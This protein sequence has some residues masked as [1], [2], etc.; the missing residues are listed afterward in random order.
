MTSAAVA[1]ATEV[2]VKVQKTS[3][4]STSDDNRSSDEPTTAPSVAMLSEADRGVGDDDDGDCDGGGDHDDD[5]DG[6]NDDDGDDG[7]NGDNDDD[8][9]DDD[10]DDVDD[11]G[12]DDDDDD[13]GGGGD[14]DFQTFSI[15]IFLPHLHRTSAHRPRPP[16]KRPSHRCTSCQSGTVR[17]KYRSESASIRH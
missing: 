16:F 3:E 17:R 1:A 4:E 5:D 15:S 8:G 11:A 9:D 7:D 2:A 12:D 14:D 10:D 13:D 6:D